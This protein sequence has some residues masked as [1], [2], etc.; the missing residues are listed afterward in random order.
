VLAAGFLSSHNCARRASAGNGIYGR[1][2]RFKL[3]QLFV[4]GNS[5][6]LG[7]H[8]GLHLRG[9]RISSTVCCRE[10]SVRRVI[11]FLPSS[12]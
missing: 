2:Y 5:L 8:W 12:T 10:F 3:P 7:L 9:L 11:K 4:L 6:A 1:Q